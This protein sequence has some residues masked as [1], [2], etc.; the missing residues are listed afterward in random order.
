[1]QTKESGSGYR[2]DVWKFIWKTLPTKMNYGE[3]S[4]CRKIL[5]ESE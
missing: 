2:Q 4:T 5:Q 1:M 3:S